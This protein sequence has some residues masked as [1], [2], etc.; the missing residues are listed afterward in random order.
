MP[1]ELRKRIAADV[2]A[3]ANDPEV[4]AKIS[5]TG[6]DVRTGGPDELAETIRQQTANT[7]NIAKIL[8][9]EKK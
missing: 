9:M 6:Q 5:A 2:I 1:L 8:G 7:A 4:K 3:A